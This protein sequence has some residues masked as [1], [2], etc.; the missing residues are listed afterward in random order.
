MMR[1]L[2]LASVLAAATL[3]TIAGWLAFREGS[4]PPTPES[5]LTIREPISDLES[6]PHGQKFELPIVVANNS[7]ETWRILKLA[8]L[9]Q[10]SCCIAA[11]LDDQVVVPP[12]SEVTYVVEVTPIRPGPFEV[13]TV[14]YIEDHGLRTLPVIVRGVAK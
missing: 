13:D 1:C 6:H 4:D 7:S 12:H 2:I 3:L 11:K 8:P 10:G 14:L 9:C 5:S